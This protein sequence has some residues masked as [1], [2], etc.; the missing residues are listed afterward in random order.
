VEIRS[1]GLARDDT[2]AVDE[3]IGTYVIDYKGT[4][5]GRVKQIH[6][7]PVNLTVEGITIDNGLFHEDD[8]VDKGYI[9]LLSNE[10]VILSDILISDYV[11]MAVV[12]STGKEVGKVS[13]VSAVGTTN[14]I[15]S[16]TV[17]RGLLRDDLVVTASMIDRV[18]EKIMLNE[19]ID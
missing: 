12:D 13:D 3:I 11:G 8:Y 15:Y 18:G 16:L 14:G 19:P 9:F 2:E 1:T 10:G 17:N 4:E 6:V 5:I 7:D